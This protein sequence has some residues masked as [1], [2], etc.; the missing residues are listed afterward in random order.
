MGDESR[1]T[2]KLQPFEIN[3]VVVVIHESYIVNIIFIFILI[4][5]KR[6]LVVVIHGDA[7]MSGDPT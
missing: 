5:K 4:V 3:F 1:V 7:V 2:L 6:N